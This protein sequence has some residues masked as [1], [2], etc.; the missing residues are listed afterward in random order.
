MKSG[1]EPKIK[2]L[3]AELQKLNEKAHLIETIK[4]RTEYSHNAILY[5]KRKEQLEN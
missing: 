1:L 2:A 5:S 4:K 3:E